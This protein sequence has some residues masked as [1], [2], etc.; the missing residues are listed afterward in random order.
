MPKP[1][2]IEFNGKIA[3]LSEHCRD[4]G[5]NVSTVRSRH[6][7]TGEPYDK[8]LEY[9]FIYGVKPISYQIY[10]NGK[11]ASLKEHSND[12]NVDDRAVY[13]RHKNTGDTLE[14]CLMYYLINGSHKHVNRGVKD[15]RLYDRWWSMKDRCYNPKNCSYPRYGGR[16]IKVCDR[17][18]IYENFE[19]D[20]LE[21]FLKHVKQFGL[22]DTQIERINYDGNYEPSNVTWATSKEQANNKSSNRIV[23]EGLTAKQFAE[24]YDIDYQVVLRR[25]KAGWTAEEII[26]TPVSRYNTRKYSVK[27]LLP[28][29]NPVYKFCDMFDYN[30]VTVYKYIKKYN[31]EPDEALARYLKNRK[32]KNK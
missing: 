19:N 3:C 15:F 18:Q 23:I 29:N 10:F 12:L 2:L 30:A 28:C 25:F 24:K 1:I 26:N 5:V 8:C 11:V 31:L 21:S 32:K 20:M 27:Y 9:Y 13:L 14:D 16:G 6:E 17:W 7:K 22:H 4:L